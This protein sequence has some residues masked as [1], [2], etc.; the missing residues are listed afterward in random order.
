VHE[1]TLMCWCRPVL[2]YLRTS[3]GTVLKF[4][5]HRA[6]DQVSVVAPFWWGGEGDADFGYEPS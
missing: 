4:L 2:E 5:M 3:D 1:D 6:L